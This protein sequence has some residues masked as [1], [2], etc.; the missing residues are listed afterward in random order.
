[1]T[2]LCHECGE[3]IDADGRC[4]NDHKQAQPCPTPDDLRAACE[5]IR[6]TWRPERLAHDE[7]RGARSLELTLLRHISDGMVRRNQNGL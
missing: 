7:Q 1:M 4:P 3:P 5:A 2:S 6:R